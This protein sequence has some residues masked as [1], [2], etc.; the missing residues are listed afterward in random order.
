MLRFEGRIGGTDIAGEKLDEAFV[1]ACLA[2]F[3]TSAFLAAADRGYDLWLDPSDQ[4]RMPKEFL[5]LLESRLRNNPQYDYARRLEQLRPPRLRL[6]EALQ[7]RYLT[8]RMDLG[9]RLSDIKPPALIPYGP[10]HPDIW[11][12]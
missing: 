12:K 1:L 5:T 6:C 8:Y 3:P 9:H 10:L 7:A 2:D 4:Q 11:A